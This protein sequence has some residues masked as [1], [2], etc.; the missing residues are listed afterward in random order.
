MKPA[1]GLSTAQPVKTVAGV[2]I[3]LKMVVPAVYAGNVK[4]PATSKPGG[5]F[6]PS[7]F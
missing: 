1:K 6:L 4:S 2:A 7:I 5:T 3:A